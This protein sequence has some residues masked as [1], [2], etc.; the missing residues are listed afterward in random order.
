MNLNDFR[1]LG[2]AAILAAGLASPLCAQ[3]TNES[4]GTT[5][6]EAI[7]E[8]YNAGDFA[9]AREGL[10]PLAEAGNATAQYRLGFMMATASGGP[11]DRAGAKKWLEAALENRHNAGYV[12]L[13]RLYLSG[14][15]EL[16]DYERAAELLEI[17]LE[18]K[19]AEA[20][21]LLG[22]LLRIGRGVEPDKDRA[23]S[24]LHGAAKAGV[25]DAQ[26]AV[27]QM[28]SRGEGVI[29]DAAQSSR[30]LLEAA[31]NGQ[32]RAQMSLYFNYK[33][34]TGFPKDEA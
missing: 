9:T 12:L 20:A 34:G 1:G 30:W 27:A 23:F 14:S 16:P 8:A 22:E 29:E 33:R 10:L 24:L 3:S 18:N 11:F 17:G 4:T 32:A 5:G 21:F 28:Y 6:I 13:A 7:E 26:F 25:A 15:P 31:E 2:V 19:Q